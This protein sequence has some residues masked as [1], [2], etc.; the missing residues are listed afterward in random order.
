[1]SKLFHKKDIKVNNFVQ[2]LIKCHD[3]QSH[4]IEFNQ[5]IPI[6]YFLPTL[7]KHPGP[8]KNQEENM[9]AMLFTN[10]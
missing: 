2:L 7:Y 5:K 6:N 1:M 10:F 3:E 8:K 4:Q 9:L